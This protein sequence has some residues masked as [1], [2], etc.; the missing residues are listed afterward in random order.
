MRNSIVRNVE[1]QVLAFRDEGSGIIVDANFIL[2]VPS[3][4][5]SFCDVFILDLIPN[6]SHRKIELCSFIPKYKRLSYPR[7]LP[8]GLVLLWH[9]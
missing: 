3:F 2:D 5:L 9:R 1:A 4:A 8:T 6:V 7:R